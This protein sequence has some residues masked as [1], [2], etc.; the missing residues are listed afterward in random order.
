MNRTLRLLSDTA[1]NLG[2]AVL[3][4]L[5]L[6]FFSGKPWSDPFFEN[7]KSAPPTGW[8]RS[9]QEWRSLPGRFEA[10]F[11]DS[12]G[13][14]AD[15]IALRNRIDRQIFGISPVTAVMQGKDGWL[16]LTD[17][18]SVDD[19]MGRPTLSD[20]ALATW[21]TVLRERHDRLAAQGIKYY[22]FIPPNKQSIYP[23]YMPASV[24]HGRLHGLD[25]LLAYL[26]RNGRP[27]WVIDARPALLAA[28]GPTLLFQVM[29]VHWT[30]LGAYIGTT[31]VADAL[32]RDGIAVN[33]PVLSRDMFVSFLT[34]PGGDLARMIGLRSDRRS[35]T[36]VTYAGPPLPC[37]QLHQATPVEM[38]SAIPERNMDLVTDCPQAGNATRALIFNDSMIEA[39]RPFIHASF[40]HTRE[41][42]TMPGDEDLQRYIDAEH[43][44]VVIEERIERELFHPP[45]P[46]PPLPAVQ[47]DPRP[48]PAARGGWADVAAPNSATLLVNGWALWESGNNP[49]LRFNSN[50]PIIGTSLVLHDRPD[51]A[52]ARNDPALRHSGFTLRLALDPA[53]TMPRDV[54]LCIWSDD[55][56]YGAYRIDFA[57]HKDWNICPGEQA[58]K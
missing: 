19:Y 17:Y 4:L 48:A 54:V 28:K 41:V 31:S 16:F 14:R 15:L 23:D 56:A 35:M 5:P 21:D 29:D 37:G 1:L 11:N 30:S 7:R 2:F 57:N 13:Y 46:P 36:A 18:R 47:Q 55:A 38:I 45:A 27:D 8:P 40:G 50:L 34:E 9:A 6:A 49:A 26:S 42:W 39:M 3:I 43:P 10:F 25:R 44:N 22:F 52:M 20:E 51:V 53:R 24:F 32:R 58:A 33:P 12:F